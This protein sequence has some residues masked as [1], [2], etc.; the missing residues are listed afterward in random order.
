MIDLPTHLPTL[1]KIKKE[2]NVKHQGKIIFLTLSGSHLYGF[3]SKNSDLDYRGTF[4]TNTNNLL[5]L[6]PPRDVIEMKDGINDIV[7]FELAKELSLAMKGNCNVLEH[8]NAKP[9]LSS[10]EFIEMREMINDCFG[11]KGVYDS[12]RGMAHQNYYKFILNGKNTVK[13]YL[14]VFRALMG[15]IHVLQT[16]KIEPNIDELKR[17]VNHVDAV[18]ELLK[19]KREGKEHDMPPEDLDKGGI[20]ESI[21]DLFLRIDKA[22]EKSSLHERPTEY[23][24]NRVNEFLRK[25][26]K[27]MIW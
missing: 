27:E 6:S 14:Y 18:K 21:N 2:I 9:L 17:H 24:Y 11:K 15:G 22:Y 25:R 19:L 12:Y 8:L 1:A 5:G 4:M 3:S 16:G 23:D 20:E 10:P 7:L 26:R 13:K